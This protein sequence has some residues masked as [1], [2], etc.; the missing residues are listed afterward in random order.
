VLQQR[1]PEGLP[2]VQ[3]KKKMSLG[4]KI[5][6]VFLALFA[7]SVFSKVIS[8]PSVNTPQEEPT[9]H[10]DLSL[11]VQ[12]FGQPDLIDSTEY[13]NPRP[14]MVTKWL[15]YKKA[16]V[17]ASYAADSLNSPPPYDKWTLI[18]FQDSI[19]KKIIEPAEVVRRMKSRK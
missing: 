3:V 1:G 14:P 6:I 17:R 19:T 13:D 15:V 4:K 7:I 8:N 5:G 12:K 16:R 18:G 11:F 10:D 9:A 2:M